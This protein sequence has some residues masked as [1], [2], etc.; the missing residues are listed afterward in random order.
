M[1]FIIFKKYYVWV[2]L[3]SCHSKLI[4]Q[5][6]ENECPI[7]FDNQIALKLKCFSLLVSASGMDLL[8]FFGYHDCNQ[9]LRILACWLEK[10]AI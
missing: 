3:M 5:S 1:F 2:D 7:Y 8:I 10:A 4:S 9:S 6:T